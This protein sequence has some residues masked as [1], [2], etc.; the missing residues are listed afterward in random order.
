MARA[1]KARA[2]FAWPQIRAVESAACP[3]DI[4]N[5]C[6]TRSA[7]RFSPTVAGRSSGKNDVT[8]SSTFSLP[9]VTAK[10]TAVEVKL[11][12]NE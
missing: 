9:S 10:P 3:T 11:L 2:Q 4:V 7:A 1:R 12:L 8:G 5:K 6:F